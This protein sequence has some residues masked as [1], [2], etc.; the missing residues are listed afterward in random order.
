MS[1]ANYGDIGCSHTEWW[2]HDEDKQEPTIISHM[3]LA[4]WWMVDNQFHENS[5]IVTKMMMNDRPPN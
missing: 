5:F 1:K 2:L 4:R 3:Y